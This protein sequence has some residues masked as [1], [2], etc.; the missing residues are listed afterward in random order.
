MVIVAT[1]Q[2]FLPDVLPEAAAYFLASA[3]AEEIGGRLTEIAGDPTQARRK[4]DAA[5]RRLA[6]EFTSLQAS[7]RLRIAYAHVLATAGLG[8]AGHIRSVAQ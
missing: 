1:R 2:G 7:Q 8:A 6:A 3:T 4:A 5:R